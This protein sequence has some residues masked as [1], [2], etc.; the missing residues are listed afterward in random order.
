MWGVA[1]YKIEQEGDTRDKRKGDYNQRHNRI[2]ICKMECQSMYKTS[3]EHG[4]SKQNNR[5]MIAGTH[6][7]WDWERAWKGS[8]LHVFCK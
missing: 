4:H 5:G 1:P 2:I 3:L 6:I 8:T 7:V